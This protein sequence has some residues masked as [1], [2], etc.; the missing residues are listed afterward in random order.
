MRIGGGIGGPLE[1]Q[2]GDFFFW[3]E[4]GFEPLLVASQLED[5]PPCYKHILGKIIVMQTW[6]HLQ[7]DI[8]KLSL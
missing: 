1:M 7:Q 6:Q 2:R 4:P 5:L 3:R 8:K